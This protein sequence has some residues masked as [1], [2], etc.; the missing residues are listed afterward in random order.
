MKKNGK[1]GHLMKDG[2]AVLEYI[3]RISMTKYSIHRNT[4]K[5]KLS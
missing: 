5:L 3:N 4:Q 1:I 2:D